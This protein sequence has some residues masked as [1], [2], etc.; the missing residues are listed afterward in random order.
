MFVADPPEGGK[1]L[2]S[3]VTGCFA[4][5]SALV[6]IIDGW[7]QR[8]D[9]HQ[10]SIRELDLAT[11][12]VVFWKSVLDASATQ[13]DERNSIKAVVSE[14][15]LRVAAKQELELKS[16]LA[17]YEPV[18]VRSAYDRI[19]LLYKPRSTYAWIPRILMYLTFAYI[20]LDLYQDGLRALT[21]P[22]VSG[23]F[24]A[25]IGLFFILRAVA[26]K[27]ARPRSR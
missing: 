6:P 20:V 21:D 10:G 27:L 17:A 8:R 24:F 4:I 15:L 2:T 3:I 13:D 5:A 1:V 25:V 19:F 16:Q 26:E 18:A 12:Q 11:K 14:N 22:L 9:A 7:K 23:L